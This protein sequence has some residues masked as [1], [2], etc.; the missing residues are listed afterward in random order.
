LI[1]VMMDNARTTRKLTIVIVDARGA[2]LPVYRR[3]VAEFPGSRILCFSDLRAAE[4]AC[5]EHAPNIIMIDDDAPS[6]VP[7][8]LD[9]H[10]RDH[11]ALR[12]AL[13]VLMS[14]RDSP[15]TEQARRSGADVF[16]PKPVDTK[17]FMA[18]LHQAVRLHAARA[19]IASQRQPA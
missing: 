10:F 9:P 2:N 1:D 16:L 8:M 6:V 7:A 18:M 13:I 11:P 5:A 19:E 14:S 17:F 3:L 4:H 15:L 12:D